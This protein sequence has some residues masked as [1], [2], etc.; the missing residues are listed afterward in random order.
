MTDRC[1]KCHIRIYAELEGSEGRPV[2]AKPITEWS[3]M[4][5]HE[6]INGILWMWY[7][8]DGYDDDDKPL[9]RWVGL[10]KKK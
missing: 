2:F 1:K 6:D 3:N 5:V 9:S 8:F 4:M 7:E 10:Y